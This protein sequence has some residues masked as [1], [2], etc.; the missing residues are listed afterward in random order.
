ML[1]VCR[2][3]SSCKVLLIYPY[4]SY[5]YWELMVESKRKFQ[6]RSILSTLS[7]WFIVILGKLRIRFYEF[8]WGTISK[9]TDKI[10]NYHYDKIKFTKLS[11]MQFFRQ[12]EINDTFFIVMFVAFSKSSR[13][14]T[15]K[16]SINQISWLGYSSI[17]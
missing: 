16:W 6:I 9:N 8:T 3:V 13:V 5:I 14:I 10:Y 17:K 1:K 4:L 2:N 11:Y 12:Y 15:D 7:H